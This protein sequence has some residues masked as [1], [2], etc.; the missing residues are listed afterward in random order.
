V[1]AKAEVLATCAVC[2]REVA[3]S[4]LRPYLVSAGTVLKA[5]PTCWARLNRRRRKGR[6]A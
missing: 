3:A 1:T 5:C 6:E 4:T 2:R